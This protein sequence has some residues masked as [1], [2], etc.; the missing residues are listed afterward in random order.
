MK[1]EV[2]VCQEVWGTVI[3]N[4]DSPEEARRKAEDWDYDGDFRPNRLGNQAVY[5]AVLTEEATEDDAQ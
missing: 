5:S 1:Y 2:T 3:V 4:A